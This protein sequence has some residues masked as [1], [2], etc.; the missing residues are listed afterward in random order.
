MEVRKLT[1][2]N[3]VQIDNSEIDNQPVLFP[4]ELCLPSF[5]KIRIEESISIEQRHIQM[6]LHS[7]LS[8][9]RV[10]GPGSNSTN[11]MSFNPRS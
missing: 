2:A 8:F 3:E 6:T 5:R 9:G 11:R 1:A 7:V 4:F 10:L